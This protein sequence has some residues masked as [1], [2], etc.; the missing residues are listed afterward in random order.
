METRDNMETQCITRI[1]MILNEIK[2]QAML[3]FLRRF[4]KELVKLLYIT[5]QTTTD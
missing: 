4:Y 1:Q 2:H 5:S 3:S